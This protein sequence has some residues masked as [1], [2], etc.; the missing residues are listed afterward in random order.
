MKVQDQ[1]FVYSQQK[2]QLKQIAAGEKAGKTL[3]PSQV[4]SSDTQNN[5]FDFTRMTMKELSQ[6]SKALYDEGVITLGQ[7]ASL[8]LHYT[9]AATGLNQGDGDV[10]SSALS[11]A[12]NEKVDVIAMQKERLRDAKANGAPASQIAFSK[13]LIHVLEAYQFGGAGKYH[14]SA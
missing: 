8:S 5:K 12:E 1:S 11:Q 4:A 3:P 2:A 6:A 9:A 7:H 10:S 13:E 14:A